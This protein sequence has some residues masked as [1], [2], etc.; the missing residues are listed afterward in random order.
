MYHAVWTPTTFRKNRERLLAGDVAR[1]FFEDVVEQARGRRLLSDEQLHGR[2]HASRGLGGPE[3]LPAEGSAAASTGRSRESDREF[4][5]RA[6]VECD[7]PVDDRSRQSAVQEGP[8]PRG[9]A[10]ISRRHPARV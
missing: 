10:A 3:K 1:A 2:W 7:A 4:P 5:W 6:P 8:G 9:Q